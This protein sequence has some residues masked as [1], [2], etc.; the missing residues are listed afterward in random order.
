MAPGDVTRC[1]RQLLEK[2]RTLK[3]E[4]LAAATKPFIGGSEVDAFMARR[5]VLVAMID[6]LVAEKGEAQVLY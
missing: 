6:K 5:D 1:D 2:I 3:K 4:D